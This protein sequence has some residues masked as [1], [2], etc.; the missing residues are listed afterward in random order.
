MT[1]ILSR[2]IEFTEAGHIY[3]V[4]GEIWPYVTGIIEAVFPSDFHCSAAK[5][6]RAADYG[7]AVHRMLEL[8]GSDELDECS[9]DPTLKPVLEQ[10][11]LAFTEEKWEIITTEKRVAH[12]LYRYAGTVDLIATDRHGKCGIVDYKT[13]AKS[14]KVP[15]QTA[16]YEGA[17]TDISTFKP[18][19]RAALY[20]TTNSHKPEYYKDPTDWNNFLS[21]LNVYRLQEKHHV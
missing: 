21:A 12:S 17:I 18:T 2:E 10:A 6:Q 4:R 8:W 19:W 7:K 15:L 20:L 14:W 13:G 16:A 5:L 3:R 9:L 11:K 1:Q